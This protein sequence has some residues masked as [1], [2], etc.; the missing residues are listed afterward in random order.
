[1][2][3]VTYCHLPQTLP[4]SVTATWLNDLPAGKRLSVTRALVRG[5]G[6]ATLVGLRLL[7]ESM[8]HL[9][10]ENFELGQIEFVTGKKPVISGG[11]DFN[12]SHSGSIA[13]CAVSTTGCI[14]IDIEE[15]RPMR[16]TQ[17][18]KRIAA[19]SEAAGVDSLE[20]F[21]SLWTKK[22]AVA[23][24][25]GATVATL[26]QITLGNGG[27]DFD[28]NRWFLSPLNVGAGYI[29]YLAHDHDDITIDLRELAPD[30]LTCA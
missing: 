3:L 16:V 11:P 30:Q 1:M 10:D 12:I 19:P 28:G 9:G 15:V 5:N 8:R 18:A 27:A 4:E 25:A 17:L 21:F 7:L 23:K 29:A 20:D 22:E 13:L 6:K 14:G 26:S 2:I 24:A